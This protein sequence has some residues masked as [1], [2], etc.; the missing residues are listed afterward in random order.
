MLRES[1]KEYEVAQKCCL[2]GLNE[3]IR[4]LT[5]AGSIPGQLPLEAHDETLARYTNSVTP[6]M[7]VPVLR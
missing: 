3:L 2:V 5:L 7:F 4:G 6:V 1:V